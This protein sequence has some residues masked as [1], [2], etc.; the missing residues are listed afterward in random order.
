MPLESHHSQIKPSLYTK[1][2]ALP[3]KA[4]LLATTDSKKDAVTL[5][6][7]V[8]PHI[9]TNS[10]PN[11]T[12]TTTTTN[13]P[14][15]HND[16]LNAHANRR[17]RPAP[18]QRLLLHPRHPPSLQGL[19]Q[20][21]AQQPL[22]ARRPTGRDGAAATLAARLPTRLS[23]RVRATSPEVKHERRRTHF[24][25]IFDVKRWGLVAMVLA[26]HLFPGLSDGEREGVSGLFLNYLYCGIK[27]HDDRSKT[28]PIFTATTMAS[29]GLFS[30]WVARLQAFRRHVIC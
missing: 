26:V 22:P 30:I 14:N 13:Q 11:K 19:G 4:K 23:I 5:I 29:E 6:D 21:A 15:H 8:L 24:P 25:I 12:Q 7:Y 17:C 20:Q 10:P 16:R 27:V 1:T 28:N 2:S 9:Q 18:A 3:N